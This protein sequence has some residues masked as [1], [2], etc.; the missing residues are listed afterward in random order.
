[1]MISCYIFPLRILAQTLR[2]RP[3][4]LDVGHRYKLLL[5]LIEMT[6]FSVRFRLDA[7]AC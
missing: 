3:P 1:M 4:L 7:E 2:C 6:A 5:S